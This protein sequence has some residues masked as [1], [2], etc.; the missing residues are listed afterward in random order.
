[1]SAG[2]EW[3]AHVLRPVSPR[4]LLLLRRH[5]INR[6]TVPLPWRWAEPQRGNWQMA[7][8]DHF[9][10]PLRTAGLPLQGALGP[11][12]A[13]ALP[14]HALSAD[15]PG[16]VERFAAASAELARL[17]PDITVFR[18]ESE[19]NAAAWWERLGTRRRRGQVWTDAGFRS[20]LLRAAVEAVKAARPDASVRVTVHAG[21]PGWKGELR[22]W[23]RDGLRFD[24]LGLTVQPCFFLPDPELAARCG[25]AVA[26]AIATLHQELGDDIPGVE[27]ARTAYPTRGARFTPRRQRRFLELAAQSVQAAGSEGLHW[28]ALRDQA[29]DDPILRYWTPSQERHYGLLYY[30]GVEKPVADAVRVLATGDRFGEGTR[31]G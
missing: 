23:I 17:T 22:R 9:L 31:T 25:E 13:H 5:G 1:M 16:F 14:D 10:A 30:D 8:L 20:A 21:L 3:G 7:P 12:M 29:H 2:F 6:V 27:I 26:E 18:V 28:W 11:V 24:R 19:L 4:E 15:E